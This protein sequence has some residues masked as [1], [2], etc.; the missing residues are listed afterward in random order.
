[1]TRVGYRA[2]ALLAPR[3][4]RLATAS[5]SRC[6]GL[7]GSVRSKF[8]ALLVP[9][10]KRWSKNGLLRIHISKL[11]EVEAPFHI[12]TSE[13]TEE[14]ADALCEVVP[15]KRKWAHHE[16]LH[17][18]CARVRHLLPRMSPRDI[19]RVT[20]A[21]GELH[22]KRKNYALLFHDYETFVSLFQALPVEAA[23]AKTLI[24]LLRTYRRMGVKHDA[25]VNAICERVAAGEVELR[26]TEL[27]ELV[28]LHG[29]LKIKAPRLFEFVAE[30]LDLR[31]AYFSEDQVGDV[32][33]TFCALRYRSPAFVQTLRRELP[34]RLHEY[35]WWNLIDIA[36][37]YLELQVDDRDIITRVGNEVFKL[38]FSMRYGYNA[39]ALKV[40]AFLETSDTRTFR[41][42]IRTLPRS[43]RTFSPL[44]AAETILACA[45]VQVEPKAVYHRL[46]G[47]KLYR[48]LVFQLSP[49][50]GALSAK[51]VCDVFAAL[52]RVKQKEG[53]LKAATEA[54]VLRRPF[55]FHLEHLV[56][57]LRDF[58][59]L[60]LTSPGIRALVVERASELSEC[61]PSALCAVPY[62]LARH[63]RGV[64]GQP[65]ALGHCALFA[66]AEEAALLAELSKLLCLPGAYA[67]PNRPGAF[68]SKDDLWFKQMRQRH[69]R[70]RR[71]AKAI[72]M[73]VAPGTSSEVPT[74][75]N[76][77]EEDD[78]AGAAAIVHVTQPECMQ[79]LDGCRDLDWRDERLLHGTVKW[80]CA[81]RRHADLAPAE[82]ASLLRT[83]SSLGFAS[84]LLRAAL[85]HALL[86]VAG[87]LAPADC[88]PALGGAL[89]VGM[90]VRSEAVRGLLRRC[91]GL[92]AFV[93]AKEHGTLLAI[94]AAVQRSA[95]EDI[96]ALLAREAA[97][98]AAPSRARVPLELY[99]FGEAVAARVHGRG[100]APAW[101]P[102]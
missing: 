87:E 80:L 40:L 35:A 15:W 97:G 64:Q 50:I 51:M 79:L 13:N 31:F 53:D 95:D 19:V 28:S 56:S 20:L 21:F 78:D 39:K 94:T 10:W 52:A 77:E 37:M 98:A 22:T 72:G 88:V 47:S 81:G 42:L 25:F 11:P 70:L 67:L 96:A 4:P 2:P 101:P 69:Y 76:E 74:T 65:D 49:E 57:L 100:G 58:G 61:T 30:T 75:A 33:R 36:E 1:M 90:D 46:R 54:L 93:P 17:G 3:L 82:V 45:A 16:W 71:R 85:E 32:A 8:D 102:T 91:T 92:L 6:L 55:K 9:P 43:V 48:M 27:V 5:S 86:R 41:L 84:P 44:V 60:G 63:P 62:A 24:P 23:T 38:I 34:Y 26:P 66:Q 89:D 29:H 68:R 14:F 12:M 83:Y 73:A 7:T 59:A 99:L 18:V